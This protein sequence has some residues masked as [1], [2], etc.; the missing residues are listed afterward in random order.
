MLL[1]VHLYRVVTTKYT[2]VPKHFI[3]NCLFLAYSR[4]LFKTQYN[5][6]TKKA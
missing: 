3:P 1:H 5:N 6:T 4:K 2:F